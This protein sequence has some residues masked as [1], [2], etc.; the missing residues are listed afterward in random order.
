MSSLS[1]AILG[2]NRISASIGL[3]LKRYEK[4]G[5]RYEF[6]ITG[7]DYSSER[8]KQAQKMGAIDKSERK[9]EKAVVNADIVIHAISYEDSEAT[10]R[11]IA[12]D[13]RD[14]VVILDLSPLKAPSL[15]WAK[16]HLTNE[17]HVVGITP[18]VNPHYLFNPNQNIELAEEDLF[19]NS[20]ILLT[21]AASC[22]K[23][24]VDLAFNFAQILG[25]KPRFLDPYEHDSLL[26]A[27]D[28]LPKLLGTLFFYNLMNQENWSDLQWFTNPAFG[29]LT[30]VLFDYHPDA[31]RD[32]FI[33]NKEALVRTTDSMIQTL[34]QFRD[35]L[36]SEEDHLVENVV[37]EA[38]ETYEKWV[39]TR[40]QADWDAVSYGPEPKAV[41]TLARGLLGGT[42]ADKIFG[43][44]DTNKK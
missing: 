4:K 41:N 32:E 3:A 30:R 10:F 37:V 17:H 13:L 7:Y 12:Q 26:A 14:G 15:E 24:A 11:T 36:E 31:L 5:R 19:D 8:S 43:E 38:A 16:T 2:L 23:E 33:K 6:S 35:I 44:D 29:A 34:Q 25:S 28:Q 20:A 27:T 39:N 22:I 18:L 1:V 21:P 42:I 40:F 9:P